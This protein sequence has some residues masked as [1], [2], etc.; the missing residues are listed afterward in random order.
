[1]LADTDGEAKTLE[2]RVQLS[3][4]TADWGNQTRSEEEMN[5]F[6]GLSVE[7]RLVYFLDL[8]AGLDSTVAYVA[9]YRV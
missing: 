9:C 8:G 5:L 3:D 2:G 4:R 1:V 6:A 7:K